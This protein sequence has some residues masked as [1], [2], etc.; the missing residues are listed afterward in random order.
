MLRHLENIVPTVLDKKS[1]NYKCQSLNFWLFVLLINT[2]NLKWALS[3]GHLNFHL[4]VIHNI[5]TQNIKKAKLGEVADSD[6]CCESNDCCESAD[7]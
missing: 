2:M 4:F 5:K 7:F 1:A 3:S 6:D